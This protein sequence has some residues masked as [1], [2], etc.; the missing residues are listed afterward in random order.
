VSG[1]P[2]TVFFENPTEVARVLLDPANLPYR[3]RVTFG[4][5]T[6]DFMVSATSDHQGS[7]H[8][9]ATEAL[10]AVNTTVT[11]G[12]AD[13]SA[14]VQVVASASEAVARN[15]QTVATA[16]AEM[17]S[18]IR[19]ITKNASD[20]AKVAGEA[21]A[22]AEPTNAMMTKL[23]DSSQEIGKVLK[24]ITSVAQQTNLLALSL[25]L[26]WRLDV[27]LIAA[28]EHDVTDRLGS[29]TGGVVAMPQARSSSWRA[30]SRRAAAGDRSE[31]LVRSG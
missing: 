1:K 19:D 3:A 24:L 17:G 13:T 11:N 31:D 7:V 20:A 4:T 28:L 9:A 29:V 15:I 23:G 14:Q 16:T 18:S 25:L 8:A 21:V 10:S 30:G 5:E 2:M 22:L 6:I 27:R 26:M 12:A